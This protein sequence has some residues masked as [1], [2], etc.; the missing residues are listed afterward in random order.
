M[1]GV[2][3]TLDEYVGTVYSVP[4]KIGPVMVPIYF[5]IMKQV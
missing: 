1:I 4:V 2:S 3:D 5:K